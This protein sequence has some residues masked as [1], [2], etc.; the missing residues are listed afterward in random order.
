MKR[1]GAAEE[2]APRTWRDSILAGGVSHRR[3]EGITLKTKT[4]SGKPVAQ[5]IRSCSLMRV[6]AV[7]IVIVLRKWAEMSLGS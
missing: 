6:K 3:G 7:D 2:A 1:E 5:N 4:S